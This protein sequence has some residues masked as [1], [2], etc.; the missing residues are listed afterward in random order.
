MVSGVMIVFNIC[1][2]I[3][4]FGVKWF[5]MVNMVVMVVVGIVSVRMI[6]CWL[7]NDIFRLVIIF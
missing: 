3:Y 1:V 2:V 4:L 5:W 7:F 6:N